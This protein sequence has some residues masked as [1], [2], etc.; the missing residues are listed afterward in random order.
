M[1]LRR[2]QQLQIFLTK[3]L[4]QYQRQQESLGP[5]FFRSFQSMKALLDLWVSSGQQFPTAF[6]FV[7]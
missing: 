5:T 1:F 2:L 6:Q 7:I 4:T 3:K